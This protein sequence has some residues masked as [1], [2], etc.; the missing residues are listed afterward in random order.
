M[1]TLDKILGSGILTQNSDGSVS[2]TMYPFQEQLT[3]QKFAKEINSGRLNVEDAYACFLA[4][5]DYSH[6]CVEDDSHGNIIYFYANNLN[7]KTSRDR[8]I[9]QIAGM[10]DKRFTESIAN[11]ASNGHLSSFM[12]QYEKD[13]SEF[14]KDLD[15]LEE[16]YYIRF[17]GLIY[18]VVLIGVGK[19]RQLK[20]RLYQ[21]LMFSMNASVQ[22]C[23]C[24]SFTYCYETDHYLEFLKERMNPTLPAPS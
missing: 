24:V 8:M 3:A 13:K 17:S 16:N 20:E 18:A 15:R 11:L 10:L 21:A 4:G 1:P 19:D 6:F 22:I 2:S 7:I 23:D 5:E 9:I 12:A 14:E